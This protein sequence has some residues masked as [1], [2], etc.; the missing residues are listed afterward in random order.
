VVCGHIHQPEIRNIVTEEGKVTYLNSG[1][2]IENLTSLEYNKGEWKI[3]TFNPESQSDDTGEDED[4][5][6]KL[7]VKKLFE[8][9]KAH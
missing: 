2:W 3:F 1:D 5:G 8:Q 4:L 6:A 9:F 7:N